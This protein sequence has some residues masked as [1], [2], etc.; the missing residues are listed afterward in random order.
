M[1]AF[2]ANAQNYSQ[3]FDG[4][5][6][7]AFNSVQ[8]YFD[9]ID[10]FNVWQVGPPQK[11]FFDEAYSP[12]NVLITD[13]TQPYPAYDTS[14]VYF[15]APLSFQG[16]GIW[17]FQWMQK[18]HFGP[19]DGGVVEFSLDDGASWSN[20][21]YSPYVYNFFGYEQANYGYTYDDGFVGEDTVWRN[22]WVC[23]DLSWAS[24]LNNEVLFRFT[25]VS[26]STGGGQI[27]DGWMIDNI[28]SQETWIHTLNEV[29]PDGYMTVFP[30][31]AS[32]RINIV[33]EK[34]NEF[35]IIEELTL[36]ASNGEVVKQYHNVPTKFFID[37]SDV[38]EGNYQLK[39]R[40]NFQ[41]EEFSVIVQH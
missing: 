27:Y 39:V 33:T 8:Y 24:S 35:H 12:P 40:T 30:N 7:S 37:V 14:T 10:S 5:D 41:E 36:Y 3:Y 13:T 6:T 19:G 2:G 17:A 29:K 16:F 21:F 18:L 22:I 31:P 15:K 26:D 38:P 11:Y 23:I 4:A 9:S 25:S 1:M 34:K 20:V 28:V 32:E